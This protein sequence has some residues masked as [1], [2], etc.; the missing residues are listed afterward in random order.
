MKRLV[1]MR[2][3]LES[4]DYFGGDNLLGGVSWFA[5]RAVLI[6]AMGE[7][8]YDDEREVFRQITGREREPLE[9]VEELTG[10][11][12]RRGGKS[13]AIA[14]VG[15]YL[16][17]CTDYRTIL[18][19]GQIGVLPIMAASREQ[20]QEIFNYCTGIFG[21]APALRG[22]VVTQ[23][24][25]TLTLSSRVELQIRSA[26][27]RRGRGFT[28]VAIILDELAWFFSDGSANPDVE[29]VA[30]ARPALA[31][32]G[33]PL[34]KISSPYGRRGVLYDDFA[35]NYGPAGDP[36]LLVV[37]APSRVMNPT[38]PQRV[39]DRAM[40][41]DPAA[42]SAEYLA[43]F[44]TDV[45]AFISREAIEA[46]VSRG[47][48]VRA[49]LPNVQYFGFND[50]SGGSSDSMTGAVAH[51]EGDVIVLDAIIERRPPFSPEAVTKE[52]SD[53]YKQFKI[54]TI[55]GDRYG[56]EWP[57]EKFRTNGINYIPC[58]LNRSELYI[59]LLPLL[60][61]GRASLLD[62]ARM[63]NQFIGLERRTTRG[64]RDSIDHG[65]GQHDDVANAVAGAISLAV[66]D[67]SVDIE[68]WANALAGVPL[69]P[70][71]KAPVAP[72]AW[73]QP[74]LDKRAAEPV[75]DELSPLEAYNRQFAKMTG[76]L[77]NP[78]GKTCRRCGGPIGATRT[79]DGVD[80][81]HPQC[82]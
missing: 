28:A 6:A 72:L 10:V 63:I 54:T 47:V 66:A 45:E 43:E 71:E 42:A 26:S 41:R 20:A 52:F 13:Q 69:Q 40:L 77:V 82:R 4:P 38:L 46:C 81:W 49:P 80:T 19:P 44:R 2:N 36:K 24:A 22:M 7:A 64:G 30:A 1:T 56:G 29:I 76:T 17:A 32:T 31:T 15:S 5:W 75:Q 57:R 18:A 35:R 55:R 11:I 14:T 8:L 62:N 79:F 37:K 33:G 61:S 3:A 9:Q 25:D 73:H 70:R 50:P 48:S 53:L 16:A 78:A 74:A 67:G 59:E 68:G 51:R 12:G 21:T 60:N 27:F 34:I 65:P 58:E 23:T 39:V